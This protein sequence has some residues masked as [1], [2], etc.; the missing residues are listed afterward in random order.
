MICYM[1][2]ACT[3]VYRCVSFE[4][5]CYIV[6]WDIVQSAAAMHCTLELCHPHNS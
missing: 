3:R 2:S 5:F 6:T 1:Q 4:R